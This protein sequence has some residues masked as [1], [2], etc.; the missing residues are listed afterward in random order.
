MPAEEQEDPEQRPRKRP[1]NSSSDAETLLDPQEEDPILAL[2]NV[3][4]CRDPRA[5]WPSTVE[6][7]AILDR[8]HGR[9]A[10][11]GSVLLLDPTLEE[12][13]LNAKWECDMKAVR[14]HCLPIKFHDVA[15]D[16]LQALIAGL[17]GDSEGFYIGA[18]VDPCWRWLGGNSDRGPMKG[19]CDNDWDRLHVLYLGQGPETAPLEASL[20][21]FAQEQFP[22]WQCHNKAPDNRGQVRGVPNCMYLVMR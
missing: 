14:S 4:P 13:E 19:H 18:T 22:P 15:Q 8:R 20:I 9:L 7:N 2:L 6:L 11:S 21:R 10:P 5:S 3:S 12:D 17:V 16:D 1:R